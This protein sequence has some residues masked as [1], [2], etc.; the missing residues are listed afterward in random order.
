MSFTIVPRTLG[1]E[2][3]EFVID[4]NGNLIVSKTVKRS[5]RVKD[6]YRGSF[7]LLDVLLYSSLAV[8]RIVNI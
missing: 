7:Y 3:T 1:I 6:E 8:M 4:T 5:P 2:A